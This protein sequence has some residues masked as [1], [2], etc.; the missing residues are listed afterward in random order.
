MGIAPEPRAILEGSVEGSP[1][2]EN[3]WTR[4]LTYL[5]V[6]ISLGAPEPFVASPG[7]M[8]MKG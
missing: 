3:H 4:G 7:V 6:R 2:F 5:Y 1:L 8:A